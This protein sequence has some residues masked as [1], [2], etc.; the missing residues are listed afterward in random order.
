MKHSGVFAN[1]DIEHPNELGTPAFVDFAFAHFSR[2][3]GLHT[4][5]VALG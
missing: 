1:L 5:L 3:A 4:W 2:M